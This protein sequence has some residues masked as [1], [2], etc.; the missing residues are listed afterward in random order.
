VP[1]AFVAFPFLILLI[2]VAII[3]FVI[4][5]A[6]MLSLKTTPTSPGQGGRH[7]LFTIQP[8]AHS[9][10]IKNFSVHS[11]IFNLH[12]ISSHAAVS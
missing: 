9:G 1:Q 2:A 5:V 11:I 6:I 10:I 4:V 7:D 8:P 3:L 12:S